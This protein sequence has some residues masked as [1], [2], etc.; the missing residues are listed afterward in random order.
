L[1]SGNSNVEV[2][3]FYYAYSN[4]AGTELMLCGR[5]SDQGLIDN[6]TVLTGDGTTAKAKTHI[7]F[8]A[9]SF[10]GQD[11]QDMEAY[12]LSLDSA[13]YAGTGLH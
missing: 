13:N 7:P 6:A 9:V 12:A 5:I 8:V 11:G 3:Y 1:G 10:D 4:T 2:I